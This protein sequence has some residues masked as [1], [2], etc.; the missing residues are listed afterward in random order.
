MR[1]LIEPGTYDCTNFGDVAMLQVAISRMRGI[2]PDAE[3]FVFSNT[4][5]ALARYCPGAIPVADSARRLWFSDRSVLGELHKRMPGAISA[6]IMRAQSLLR[7]HAPALLRAVIRLKARRYPGEKAAFDAFL[8]A[9]DRADLHLLCGQGTFSDTGVVQAEIVLR[10]M[11]M[12]MRSG[13]PAA[14][15]GQGIGPV[16][17]PRLVAIMREVA[18]GACLIALREGRSGPAVLRSLEVAPERVIVTGDD[19]VELAYSERPS[20]LG[21]G[22][23]LNVRVAPNAGIGPAVIGQLKCVLN[24]FTDRHPVPVVPLPIAAHGSI[25]D[26]RVIRDLLA[27]IDSS[28]TGGAELEMPMQ[29]IAQAGECRLVIAGAYHAAI[30][31]LSQGVSV[32]CLCA[33]TY[34]AEK[35]LGLRDLFGDGCRLVR[36]DKPSWASELAAEMTTA[37]DAADDVREGLLRSAED[38]IASGKAAIGR[39]TSAC[40]NVA[41]PPAFIPAIKWVDRA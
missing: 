22:L 37:W 24:A 21:K 17:E 4:P 6:R 28:S 32:I 40:R 18:P 7:Q 19:A 23:G 29:V 2:Y 10:T 3:F 8:N 14:M 34:Y 1:I 16:T 25:Q 35:F 30:F 36:I 38:Q 41:P 15:I 27:D 11:Q 39:L 12:S 13:T 20:V 31:A 5:D 33:S 26:A 9:M